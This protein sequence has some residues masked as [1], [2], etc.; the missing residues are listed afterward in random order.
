MNDDL[1]QEIEHLKRRL[2]NFGAELRAEKHVHDVLIQ[3]QEA[4]REYCKRLLD[5]DRPS[6]AQ[7]GANVLQLLEPELKPPPKGHKER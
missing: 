4:V 6:V 2:K 3:R 5:D 1:D 7:V